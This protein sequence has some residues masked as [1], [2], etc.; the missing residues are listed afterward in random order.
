M[1]QA[2]YVPR[3]G[4]V[5]TLPQRHRPS[6][7]LVA[8]DFKRLQLHGL[9]RHPYAVRDFV[10]DVVGITLLIALWMVMLYSLGAL[11]P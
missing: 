7:Q 8:H 10:K 2:R 5:I 6:L 11:A 4:N 3:H 9:G 1:T